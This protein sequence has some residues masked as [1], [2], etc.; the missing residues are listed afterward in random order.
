MSIFKNLETDSM[1]EV[2]DYTG[3]SSTVPSNIYKA[4]IKVAYEGVSPKGAA[5]V[6]YVFDLDNREFSETV[7]VTS[8]TGNPYYEKDGKKFPLPGY[9]RANAIAMMVTGKELSDQTTATKVVK[10][11]DPDLGK[12]TNQEVQMH[13][14]LIDGEVYLGIL[15]VVKDKYQGDGTVTINEIDSVF[16]VETKQTLSEA[17]NER[18]PNFWD[19]WLANNEGKTRDI[20]GKSSGKSTPQRS[21]DNGSSKRTKSLFS[22]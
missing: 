2:Q 15:E 21:S 19:K 5:Y 13:I 6:R 9:S 8:R 17:L 16:H 22:K 11:Y 14:D 12:E 20:S 1:E 18:E 10:A 4:K 3:G 7:Y